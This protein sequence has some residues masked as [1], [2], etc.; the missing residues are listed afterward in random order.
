MELG[1]LTLKA[2]RIS[3]NSILPIPKIQK[4]FLNLNLDQFLKRISAVKLAQNFKDDD[5]RTTTT[6]ESSHYLGCQGSCAVSPRFRSLD[7]HAPFKT[8]KTKW[9][10]EGVKGCSEIDF[11]SN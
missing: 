11:I 2:S 10:M 3:Q 6:W 1:D 8:Y 4:G 9:L 5:L 7:C